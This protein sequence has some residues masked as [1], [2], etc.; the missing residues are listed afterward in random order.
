MASFAYYSS[1]WS[2]TRDIPLAFK[3]T[4]K[5]SVI[6]KYKAVSYFSLSVT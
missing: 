2:A 6:E 5:A 4:L 3:T 1:L